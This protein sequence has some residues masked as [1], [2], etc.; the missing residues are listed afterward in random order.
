MLPTD[1]RHWWPIIEDVFSSPPIAKLKMD[2]MRAFC[3]LQEF[4]VLSVDA[5]IKRC[6]GVL[7][8]ESYRAPKAKRNAAPFGDDEALRRVLTVRGRSGA[9][10]GTRAVPSEK[11]EDIRIALAEMLPA[12]GLRQVQ[13]LS[14]DSASIKLYTELKCVMPNM[15]CLALDPIHL[16]IVYEHL[17]CVREQL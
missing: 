11:A 3:D 13:C 17:A 8:Q 14:S 4:Q 16:S 12:E 15:Q 7:G 1:V 2:L 5:T 6:M 9:V 10:L